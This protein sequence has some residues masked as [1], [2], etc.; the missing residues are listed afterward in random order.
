MGN[1]SSNIN[2]RS[3]ILEGALVGASRN[4]FPENKSRKEELSRPLLL[5]Q[6]LLVAK[7]LPQLLSGLISLA[8][9]ALPSF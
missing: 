2:P 4:D 3:I 9:K 8:A 5:Y 7:L 1:V 6:T